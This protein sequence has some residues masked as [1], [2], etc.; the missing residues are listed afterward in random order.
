[1]MQRLAKIFAHVTAFLLI[2]TVAFSQ[3]V[4][5]V[6]DFVVG[7][8]FQTSP[9]SLTNGASSPFQLDASGNL[10]VN[11][12]AGGGSG[13]TSSTFGAA[14]P[15]TGT[16]IGAKNGLNMVNL[17]ADASNN[18][19]VNCVVGCSGGTSSNASDAVATSSTN[20][21]TLAFGYAFNGTTW[22]RLQDD[23]SKSLKV[24][25]ASGTLPAF[26]SNPTFILGAGSAIAGKFTTDLTTPGTTNG[27]AINPTSN[28]AAGITPVVSSA[29]ESGHV[30]KASAGNLYSVYV[31]T[32]AVAGFLMVFNSTTVPADGA[33]TPI[34]CQPAPANGIASLT[35]NPGPVESYS[36]GIS[37]AFS[38]TGCFTKTASATAFFHGV[39]Q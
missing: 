11:V 21:Q 20:G 9:P 36:T 28:A 10:K 32:G 15:G 13:G 3:A 39:I 37:V 33:V 25:I 18:L 31:T 8:L 24:T 5:L 7:G 4:R 27:I 12:T 23:G 29:V 26:A 17:A 22:D 2:S 14:F 35:F 1:M 6:P 38:T 30:L 34:E 16:A 19:D